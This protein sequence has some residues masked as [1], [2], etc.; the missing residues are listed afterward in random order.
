M[1]N[2]GGRPLGWR[3]LVKLDPVEEVTKGGIIIPET[4]GRGRARTTGTLVAVGKFA[5]R[6]KDGNYKP[7]AR[8]GNKVLFSKYD[9]KL[10]KL[11]ADPDNDY[12]VLNDDDIQFAF[13]SEVKE[14]ELPE[15][16]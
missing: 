3:I 12:M 15:E 5:W 4:E 9:G 14:H 13:D 2:L 11:P 7:W 10:I 1:N 8:V 6:D 16:V